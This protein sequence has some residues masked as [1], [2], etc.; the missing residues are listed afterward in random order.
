MTAPAQSAARKRK[1]S[2]V[3]V[4]L[5]HLPKEALENFQKNYEKEIA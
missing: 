2:E 1:P 3:K 4:W 5:K